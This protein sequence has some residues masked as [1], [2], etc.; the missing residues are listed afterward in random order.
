MWERGFSFLILD[1]QSSDKKSAVNSRT[2]SENDSDVMT[3]GR[4]PD[5]CRRIIFVRDMILTV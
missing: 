5:L 4:T 3:E 1:Y 2:D